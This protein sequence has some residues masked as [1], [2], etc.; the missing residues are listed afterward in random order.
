VDGSVTGAKA[1]YLDELIAR[2]STWGKWG[3]DDELGAANYLT[4]EKVREGIELAREGRVFSLSLPFDENGPQSGAWGRCNPMH[5]MLQ[6]G[7]DI[8]VGAQRELGLEYTDDAIYMP[9]QCGTQWDA[10]AH[11]FHNGRMYNNR[12]TEL[13]TSSGAKKNAITALSSRMVSRGVLLDIAGSL[14]KPWL[15]E[16]DRVT[17]ESLYWAEEFAGTEVRQGDIVL[18]RTGR[19]GAARERGSWGPEYSGGAAPG[20]TLGAAEFFCSKGIAAVAI[21][22][23]SAEFTPSEL[24]EYRYPLHIVLIVYAGVVIGE[25]YDLEDLAADCAADGR[26]EFLFSAPPLPV[27]GGVGSPV[28]PLAIK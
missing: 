3:P 11:C 19:I 10:L 15:S 27:T 6:D 4:P 16:S 8:A 13:V 5:I 25:L 21:D 1:E 2:H 18:V 12:G 22:T 24:P 17:A 7:G 23:W 9:L 20:L 28:N 14:G 26:Y